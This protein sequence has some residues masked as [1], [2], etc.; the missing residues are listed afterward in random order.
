ML[1]GEKK[2]RIGVIGAGPAGLAT[3]RVL[4]RYPERYKVV[5][6]ESRSDIGGVW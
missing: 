3:L 5:A 2:V 4:A 1:L 6:F